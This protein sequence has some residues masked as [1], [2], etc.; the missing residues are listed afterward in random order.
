[1]PANL[2]CISFNVG[3]LCTGLISACFVKPS[4][5][6]AESYFTICFRNEHKAV[7]QF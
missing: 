3:P 2:G 4:W 6:Q 5:V 1:M 7:G